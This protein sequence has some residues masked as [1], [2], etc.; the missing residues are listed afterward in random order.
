[1]CLCASRAP[2][3]EQGAHR[4]ACASIQPSRRLFSDR[5]Q[6]WTATA[7]RTRK[8]VLPPRERERREGN[9]GSVVPCWMRATQSNRTLSLSSSTSSSTCS[10]SNQR[11]TSRLRLPAQTR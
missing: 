9:L 2:S 7:V 11:L 5:P 10:S 3:R 1:V 4:I 6:G 8:T